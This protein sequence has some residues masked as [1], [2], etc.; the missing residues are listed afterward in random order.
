VRRGVESG[1]NRKIATTGVTMMVTTPQNRSAPI[2]SSE[3]LDHRGASIALLGRT[4]P[5]PPGA[6]KEDVEA[7]WREINWRGDKWEYYRRMVLVCVIGAL[8]CGLI[9]SA[10]VVWLR[11]WEYAVVIAIGPIIGITLAKLILPATKAA[12]QGLYLGIGRCPQC[13]YRLSDLK[14]EADGCVVCPECGA[15]WRS[16]AIERPSGEGRGR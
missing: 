12:S 10:A 13:A 4:L 15:A 11:G 8:F 6:S 14:P 16:D 1:V 2:R 7:A 3:S 9:G 5:L